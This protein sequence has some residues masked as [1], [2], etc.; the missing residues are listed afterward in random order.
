VADYLSK[1]AKKGIP[2]P[3]L[4]FPPREDRYSNFKKLSPKEIN[5]PADKAAM[6]LIR[7]GIT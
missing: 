4:A 7:Q 1:F 2:V 3:V 6:L 5:D